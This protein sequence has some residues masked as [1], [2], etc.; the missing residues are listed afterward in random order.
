MRT[1]LASRIRS[2][3]LLLREHADYFASHAHARA[4][5]RK[6]IGL[7][8]TAYGDRARARRAFASSLAARPDAATVGHLL[9]AV[10][11]STRRVEA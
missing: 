9:R 5:A 6:R 8:A 11:R 3:E 4:F 7:M 10:G 2:R 1:G